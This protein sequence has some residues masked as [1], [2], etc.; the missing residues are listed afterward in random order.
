MLCTKCG[1]N[2]EENSKFCDNCGAD[3]SEI[4]ETQNDAKDIPALE[5]SPVVEN[6]VQSDQTPV[7]EKTEIQEE[8]SAVVEEIAPETTE[9]E[10]VKKS[11]KTRKTI[12]IAL[13][14]CV[15][16]VLFWD[17]VFA[18]VAPKLYAQTV[19]NKTIDR[20]NDEILKS[21]KNILGFNLENEK[22]LTASMEAVL[23]E[24]AGKKLDGLGVRATATD[25]QKKKKFMYNA[26]LVYDEKTLA[27]AI[28]TLDD[29]NIYLD[30]PEFF[31]KSLIVP[32]KDFGKAW[33]NSEIADELDVKLDEKLF[34]LSYS[35]LSKKQK[36]SLL[37]KKSEKS[38]E[39]EIAKLIK[40][41]K[42]EN[43]KGSATVND[44]TVT[45]KAITI[46]IDP[47]DFEDMLNNS[48][49]I[50]EKDEN[51]KKMFDSSNEVEDSMEE[52]FDG[53]RDGVEGLCDVIDDEIIL[54]L[55]VYKGEA[56]CIAC[57]LA[58]DGGASIRMEMAF[59]DSK[60]F[61]NDT[62]MLVEVKVNGQKIA[63]E[64]DS[65]GNH[66]AKGKVFTDA[67]VIKVKA[68]GQ[69]LAEVEHT[70]TM[71]MKKNVYEQ[72]VMIK[73]NDKK[74]G[75][76]FEGTCSNKKEFN[77]VIDKFKVKGG[78]SSEVAEVIPD[79]KGKLSLTITPGAKFE[80]VDTSGSL[81]VFSADEDDLQ[82][83]AEDVE[84]KAE[85]FAVENEEAIMDVAQDFGG[86]VP[87]SY[88]DYYYE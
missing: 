16:G 42:V 15:L 26:E 3:L 64:V 75:F 66:I 36:D 17:T 1:A 28:F 41:S 67:T 40:R 9:F 71:D 82:K 10:L 60:T 38:I 6:E 39:K 70:M 84:E 79:I 87:Q 76:A 7:E 69:K 20:V 43:S 59:E 44:K 52:L 56:V 13:A 86:V 68:A 25:S 63:F 62:R 18:A 83:W 49:D 2:N 54:E 46:I 81:N 65:E 48:I 12:L 80:K 47:D 34:D 73:A 77:L 27:S 53:L 35:N 55:Q 24:F 50:I 72:E 58:V 57:E 32:S 45:T 61:I 85:E 37:S 11:G 4:K 23:N 21:E 22:E 78:N 19:L 88:P 51:I 30:S 33:N 5:V 14:I 8:A 74:F 29:K 31:K